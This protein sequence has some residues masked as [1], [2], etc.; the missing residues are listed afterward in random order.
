MKKRSLAVLCTLLFFLLCACRNASE[1]LISPVTFYYCN[2]AVAYN[3][4]EG[5]IRGEIREGKDF[6]TDTAGMLREYFTGPQSEELLSPFPAGT[7]L[8]SLS[9][10]EDTA[11]LTLSREFADLNG[12]KLSTACSCIVKTLAEFESVTRVQFFAE[13]SLLENKESLTVTVEDV[14]LTDFVEQK[15]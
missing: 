8:V 3:S 5:V 6:Q 2:R 11:M 4:A 12:I 15:G 9:I 14:I 10:E 1:E 7:K 13:G